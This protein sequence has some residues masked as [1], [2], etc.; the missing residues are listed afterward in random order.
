LRIV[1][2]VIISILL[3][4]LLS[5]CQSK[6]TNKWNPP[7]FVKEW[8]IKEI[9]PGLPH[10]IIS[11]TANKNGVFVLVKAVER[12]STPPRKWSELTQEEK[13]KEIRQMKFLFGHILNEDERLADKGGVFSKK[14]ELRHFRIQQYSLKGDFIKQ[15]PETTLQLSDEIKN[16]VGS[17][18]VRKN[19]GAEE[20]DSRFELVDPL[21]VASD[22]EGNIYAVD[23]KGNKI[24]KFNDKGDV[25]TLWK[26]VRKESLGGYYDDL[27]HQRGLSVSNGNIYIVSEGIKLH[28]SKGSTPFLPRLSKYDLNGKL[29]KEMTINPPK[30]AARIPIV[31]KK[32]PFVKDEANVSNL[33]VDN[34]GN[35]YLFAADT[36]I[37]K[38]DNKW[39]EKGYIKT[40]LK[41]GFEK[42]KQ[43]YDP[44]SK[45]T[46]NYE[47]IILKM[48][49][50]SFHSFSSDKISW[51]ENGPGLYYA[52]RIH[53]SP[54][55]EI[56][57]SFIGSKPFGVIDAMVVNE[58][59]KMLGYWKNLQKSYAPWFEKLTDLEKL[60]TIDTV[61]DFAFQGDNV[62]IGRTLRDG[63]DSRK[64]HTVIQKFTR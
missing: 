45:R 1:T 52:S 46:M 14:E 32:I 56:Y 48:T 61:V 20:V 25:V 60:E 13:E 34:E 17:I 51:I 28:R 37:L 43:V 30:V 26:I 8:E 29:I 9:K 35:L 59:G 15:W 38:L 31:G 42:P 11:M 27:Q 63:T 58:D 33:A 49:G 47:D 5:S 19:A 16:S 4:F 39:N 55:N 41:E 3:S 54:A 50:V 36:R 12:K 18:L 53:M 24:V 22:R 62:F 7:K 44:V 64:Y 21:D 57:V 2:L 40:V 6:E 10:H 23:Y